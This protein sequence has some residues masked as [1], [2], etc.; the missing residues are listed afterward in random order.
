MPEEAQV[1]WIDEPVFDDGFPFVHRIRQMLCEESIQKVIHAWK[2]HEAAWELATEKAEQAHVKKTGKPSEYTRRSMIY[3]RTLD[4]YRDKA[5]A[6]FWK[7][8]ASLPEN[9]RL[10]QPR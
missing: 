8:V 3:Y 2:T 5:C 1:P 4:K 9:Q 6:D 10:H 7:V